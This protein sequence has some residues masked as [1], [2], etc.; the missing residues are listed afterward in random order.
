MRACP[1]LPAGAAWGCGRGC[2]RGRGRLPP[3]GVIGVDV[4]WD[5]VTVGA[6]GCEPGGRA[7]WLS[8]GMNL[9]W[10]CPC[11]RHG[12]RLLTKAVAQ[13][14]GCG[15]AQWSPLGRPLF[16]GTSQYWVGDV[17][18][19]E[20]GGRGLRGPRQPRPQRPAWGSRPRCPA[21]E[22][23]V[24]GREDQDRARLGPSGAGGR[25][26]GPTGGP[27]AGGQWD[28]EWEEVARL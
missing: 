16:W 12:S 11:R 23:R 10:I 9:E 28:L 25:V 17:R 1:R 19:A 26:L 15:G 3:C 4:S 13:N 27:G 22:G 2:G 24:G 8:A 7:G 5:A 20:R 14:T 6:A 18:L 21:V